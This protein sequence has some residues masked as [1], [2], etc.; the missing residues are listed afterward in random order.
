MQLIF[1]SNHNFVI[2]FNMMIVLVVGVF[3]IILLIYCI[4][5]IKKQGWTLLKISFLVISFLMIS[6]SLFN[7]INYQ[8]IFNQYKK[9]NIGLY[10]NSSNGYFIKLNQD[11]TWSSSQEIFICNKGEWEYILD[12]DGEWINLLGNCEQYFHYQFTPAEDN[13]TIVIY[14]ENGESYNDVI[15]VF[16]KD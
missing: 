9:E 4:K 16:K 8:I 5:K 10:I 3:G 6:F 15:Q 2:F 14:L 13:K 7:F 11:M 12:E 1:P